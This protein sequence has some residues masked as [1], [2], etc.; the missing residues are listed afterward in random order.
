M[1]YYKTKSEIEL[2]RESSLLVA[3]T[4]ATVAAY[5]RPGVKT[6][7]LDEIAEEFIRDNDALP[8]FKGYRGFPF[9]LCISVNEVVVHGFPSDYEMKEGDIVSIDCGVKKNGFVGDSAYT[10]SVGE[11]SEEN[12][13]LLNVTKEALYKG[14]ENAVHGK[15]LGDVSW[16]I[17]E[18]TEKKHG[19]GVVRELVGH[20]VGK[21]L[22][23]KPDVP[24]FGKRGRGIV[25]KEGLVLAIEPMINAG[26]K[27]VFQKDDGW[28][29]VTRDGSV[30]AH[31][32][33][34]V[35]IA[36]GEADILSSFEPIEAA[37]AKNEELSLV[38]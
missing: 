28:S 32:E 14:I 20:G 11:I 26:G 27:E 29:I 5:I 3:G 4:H 25:L 22:H 1:I 36:R 30:S 35:A 16:A 7:R 12:K 17:Q 37:V 31:F 21:D 6:S 9:S 34:T 19:F 23:E 24:N 15:R 2:I 33:H 18:H 38:V 10:Y 13:I 8:M